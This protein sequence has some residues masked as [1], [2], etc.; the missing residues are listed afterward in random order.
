[1]RP[2]GDACEP[3]ATAGFRAARLGRSF[4]FLL[5]GL[6]CWLLFSGVAS[7]DPAA[8]LDVPA[9]PHSAAGS[10]VDSDDSRSRG[11]SKSEGAGAAESG[12]AQ[13]AVQRAADDAESAV[14]GAG[15]AEP[16][17]APD[18][19]ADAVTDEAVPAAR[20]AVQTAKEVINTD[21]PESGVAPV[22]ETV[23]SLRGEAS[24]VVED[25]ENAAPPVP[26]VPPLTEPAA[27]RPDA[28]MSPAPAGVVGAQESGPPV[29][30][31]GPFL[32]MESIAA[33]PMPVWI[34]EPEPATPLSPLSF[35]G[36]RNGLGV[37]GN[38]SAQTEPVLFAALAAAM[39][40]LFG[41]FVRWERGGT[42]S[43]AVRP[44]LSPD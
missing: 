9:A 11:A 4:F 28:G 6:L 36:E 21:T 18:A 26:G 22:D 16:E 1:M 29:G 32:A 35:P 27:P 17:Q 14:S 23:G 39:L 19:A 24:R 34:G 30:P 15:S 33:Q 13:A 8:D 41:Q 31:F 5:G 2:R 3:R 42:R 10:T 44:E 7:A 43:R 40:V 20:Q 12:A 38:S 25:V 37:I